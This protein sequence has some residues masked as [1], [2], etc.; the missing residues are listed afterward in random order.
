MLGLLCAMGEVPHDCERAMCFHKDGPSEDLQRA[1]G[2]KE[3]TEHAQCDV[4]HE[5]IEINGNELH[6]CPLA[7]L[8]EQR[9]M[10]PALNYFN[11]IFDP[12]GIMPGPGGFHDQPASWCSAMMTLQGEKNRLG[13]KAHHRTNKRIEQA[14]SRR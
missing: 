2:C 5:P 12:K 7:Y 9:G 11:A 6:R 8:R 14:Q 10:R 4:D 13:N 1:W 3:E